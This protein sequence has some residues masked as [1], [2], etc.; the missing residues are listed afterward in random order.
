M[1]AD[2][3]LMVLGAVLAL[4]I[5]G[6][7]QSSATPGGS[8]RADE[9]VQELRQ[10]PA[11]LPGIAR[12]DGGPDP[13]EERRRRVYDELRALGAASQPALVRVLTDPDIQVRRNVALF[14]GVA[15]GGWYEPAQPRLDIRPCLSAL[16]A[17]LKDSDARVRELA[18]QA[19]DAIDRQ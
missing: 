7:A 18:A 2:P 13:T 3:I 11:S 5:S 8:G 9:L 12:S 16:T 1:L 19:I 17:A 14:L 6:P 4:S 10:F 15:A